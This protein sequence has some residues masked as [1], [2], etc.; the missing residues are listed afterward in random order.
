M[1]L[2]GI[3]WALS[4]NAVSQVA[5]INEAKDRKPGLFA[6]MPDSIA[7]EISTLNALVNL[8]AGSDVVIPLSEARLPLK[9]TVLANSQKFNGR[10]H[11]VSLRSSTAP[12]AI[13]H[14]TRTVLDDGS[15][16]FRGTWMHRDYSELYQLTGN[17]GNYLLVKKKF[18]DLVIE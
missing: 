3:A 7:V 10:I 17:A 5:G 9:G 14:L 13:F 4:F 15:V 8:E 6:Q 1:Y 12:G 18:T 11:S 2:L 16:V